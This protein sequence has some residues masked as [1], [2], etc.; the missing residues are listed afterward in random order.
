MAG[1]GGPGLP[2]R[3]TRHLRGGGV[4]DRPAV[5]AGP[6]GGDLPGRRH[7]P[8][9]RDMG[10]VRAAMADGRFAAL[11]AD[12]TSYGT[13]LAGFFLVIQG[14]ITDALGALLL[15]S[16]A[17]TLRHGPP[18]GVLEPDQWQ[19]SPEPPLSDRR[20]DRAPPPAAARACSTV[21]PML[22]NRRAAPCR[23]SSAA[24]AAQYLA[25]LVFACLPDR[26]GRPARRLK[27]TSV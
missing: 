6:G 21:P 4:G 13:L 10:R 19:R 8:G 14:F 20:D 27:E 1:A 26:C 2:F 17:A 24:P 22:A 18:G 16:L 11:Q 25:G 15:G 7:D 5:G 23:W 3:R 9:G 12:N